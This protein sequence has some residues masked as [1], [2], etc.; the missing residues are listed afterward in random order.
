MPEYKWPEMNQRTLLGKRVSRLDGPDKV[1]G[2]AK[3][4]SD[5]KRPGMLFA[6]FLR[7]PYAHAKLVSVDVGEAEKTPGVKAV[8]VLKEPG[9]EILWALDEIVAVAA[10]NEHIAEDAIRK[11]KVEYEKLPYLVNEADLS[12]AGKWAKKP[13]E[14]VQGDPDKAF[15]EAEVISEGEYGIPV[16]AHCTLEPHGQALEWEGQN[17]TVYPSTQGVS[18]MA[19]QYAQPLQIP[20]S[21]I[22]VRMDH[23]GGGFGSKFSADSWGIQS[24]QLAKKAGRPLKTFLERE[25]DLYVAGNRPSAFARVKVGAKKDGTLLAWQSESWGTG[26]PTGGGLPVTGV[27]PYVVNVPNARKK[28]TAVVTHTGAQRAWR[29][30]N[31]PQACYLTMAAL[32]DMAAKLGMDSLEFFIKNIGLTGERSELYRKELLK[33]A[34]LIEWKKKWH[35]RGD[36]TPGHIK[37]GLGLSMHTW[38]G[39]GHDS[40]A[41]VTINP[42]GTVSVDIGSQDLG[43][44]TRT[45]I[46]MVAAE[47]FGLPVSAI[48][49]NIGRA[50]DYPDSGASGGS[51]TVGGVSS[52]TRRGTLLALENLFAKVA[53]SLG[54]DATQ[55][56]AVGGKVQVKG[57]PARSLTWK[58][59]TA[60]LGVT[61]ITVSGKNP[62]PGNLI[63]SGVGGAQMADVS[64]DTETGIIK[65][66]KF[67][68]V[69]DCGLIINE[70]TAES[71]CYGAMIMG[72]GYSLFEERVMDDSTG[73]QLNANME[74]YKLAGL[75]DIGEL[76]VHMWRDP[77]QDGRGVIGLG[78]PPV[79]SPG[80]AIGNA[81]A[82]AIGVRV[83]RLPYT[84]ARVLAA[85]ERKGG[86][87]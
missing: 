86:L 52:S 27:F 56:E 8:T 23:V 45:V 67:V 31:H 48:K 22:K 17:L 77:E 46:A 11:I 63:N 76:V 68:A 1:S 84:P 43:T 18:S 33:A 61:S 24:A 58:Q 29:A 87:A 54:G 30:P 10:E 83:P 72:I 53:P 15:Q 21:S 34:E 59:A 32:D 26:G 16:I 60:K 79:I 6:R 66:N 55:L 81:V 3:Y 65:I 49:V 38:G 20:Q 2:K 9:A 28:N 57:N 40:E 64:V 50:P 71:Q 78:E 85:L 35:P 44:G 75:G 42:D 12:K 4:S 5:V 36:P 82:N 47:T 13:T 69:Q 7:C 80:A 41:R 62:G 25:A 37:R 19:Q 74:F 70:K 14:H 39:R 73:R 51:T